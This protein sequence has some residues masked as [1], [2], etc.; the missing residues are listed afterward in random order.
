MEMGTR[1]DIWG[2]LQIPAIFDLSHDFILIVRERKQTFVVCM[3]LRCFEDELPPRF[4]S[5]Q[6]FPNRFSS[7]SEHEEERVPLRMTAVKQ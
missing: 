6:A 2:L 1:L 5:F 3:R 4:L 7:S